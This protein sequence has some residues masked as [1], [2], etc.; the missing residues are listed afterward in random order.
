[1]PED[2]RESILEHSQWEDEKDQIKDKKGRNE[3]KKWL[4][5]FH[6]RMKNYVEV[7]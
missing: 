2:I 3:R 6:E 1:M 5:D 4:L 7:V